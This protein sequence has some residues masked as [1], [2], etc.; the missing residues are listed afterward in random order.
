[1]TLLYIF[2]KPEAVRFFGGGLKRYYNYNSQIVKST[3][4][5]FIAKSILFVLRRFAKALACQGA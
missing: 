1:M 4:N 5:K 3:S 2:L